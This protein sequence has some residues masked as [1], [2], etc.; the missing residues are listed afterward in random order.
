[1]IDVSFIAMMVGLCL[2]V[3]A[4]LLFSQIEQRGFLV[5]RIWLLSAPIVTNIISHPTSNPFF[6]PPGL[7]RGIQL[8][9]IFDPTRLFFNAFIIVALLRFA[10]NRRSSVPW[11]RTEVWMGV[12][13]VVALTNVLLLSKQTATSLRV[14]IDAFVIPFTAYYLTR[15]LVTSENDFLRLM[16]VMGYV[17]FYLIVIALIE[18][19]TRGLSG[20]LYRLTGPFE[21]RDLLYIVIMVSFF[22]VLLGSVHDKERVDQRRELAPGVRRFVVVLAPL[23]VLLTWTR[24]NWLGFISGVWLVLFLGRRLL[25]FYFKK[26]AVALVLLL[27]PGIF[28]LVGS[29]LSGDVEERITNTQNIYER[30]AAWQ[31]ALRTSTKNP[32]FGIGLNNLRDVLSTEGMSFEGV[33][34]LTL[35]HNCYLGFLAELGSVGL[36]AYLLIMSSIIRMGLRLYRA[37]TRYRDRWRGIAVIAIMAAYLVPAFFSTILYRPAVSHIYVFACIGGLAGLYGS[38]RRVQGMKNS[39][40]SYAQPVLE[41]SQVA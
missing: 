10:S 3:W 5:L 39:K 20:S 21:T 32:I 1:M 27:L 38:R 2:L 33:R 29:S 37:G 24:G 30:V 6:T 23:I 17:G 15:R 25:G 11:D 13:S 26:C 22:T 12:F 9:E 28:F 31:E 36:L 41:L 4:P 16:K 8:Q 18:Q 40:N 34:N 7:E 19:F 14:A 35:H